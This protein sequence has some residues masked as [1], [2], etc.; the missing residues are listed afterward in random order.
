MN[1]SVESIN[2]VADKEFQK[3]LK[4]LHNR[5][6]PYDLNLEAS[7]ADKSGT[8]L[9]KAILALTE[10]VQDLAGRTVQPVTRRVQAYGSGSSIEEA[11]VKATKNALVL[12]GV[13]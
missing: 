1:V 7:G 9:V 10:P 13:Q 11:Q 4:K 3:L 8:F 6:E 5:T 12:A 2:N